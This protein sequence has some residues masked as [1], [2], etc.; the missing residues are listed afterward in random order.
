MRDAVIVEVTGLLV[1]P[2]RLDALARALRSLLGQMVL[3]QRMGLAEHSRA[4][5][6]YCWDRIATDAE[7]V[8]ESVCNR[9]PAHT[10]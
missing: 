9:E 10:H 6:R 5:S 7:V 2:G 8:H 1:S 4:P 3:R